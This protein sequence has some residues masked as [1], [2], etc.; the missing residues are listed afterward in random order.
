[1]IKLTEE[2]NSTVFPW[3]LVG[4]PSPIKRVRRRRLDEHMIAKIFLIAGA[5]SRRTQLDNGRWTK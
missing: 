5:S 3:I 2:S 1:M 4:Y